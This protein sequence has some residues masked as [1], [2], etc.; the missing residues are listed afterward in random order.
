[1]P[2]LNWD[3]SSIN[4][5]TTTHFWVYWAV[6]GPL[7]IVTMA[8]VITWS[9][10]HSRRTRTLIKQARDT[11]LSADSSEAASV[12]SHSIKNEKRG[13]SLD[14]VSVREGDAQSVRGSAREGSFRAPS[15]KKR[16]T[17]PNFMR[18]PRKEEMRRDLGRRDTF[19]SMA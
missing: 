11:L 18:D 15:L 16:F 3:S 12:K 2:L 7:T 6:T 10:W 9:I 4:K 17:M 1:M 14:V 13:N 8:V 5:V 19:N